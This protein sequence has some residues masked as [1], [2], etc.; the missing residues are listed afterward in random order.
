MADRDKL[1]QDPA[2]DDED[3]E[4]AANHKGPPPLWVVF[5]DV[6]VHPE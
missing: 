3:E 2:E 1:H 4:G 6:D 5:E